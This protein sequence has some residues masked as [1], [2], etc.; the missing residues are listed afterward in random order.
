[1]IDFYKRD[2]NPINFS[3]IYTNCNFPIY[4]GEVVILQAPPAS[5]K[6]M[7]LQNLMVAFKK[8]TYFI[9]MEMSPRQI[10]SRFAMI[11][12]GWTEEQLADHY[13]Q[14][15]NGISQSFNWLT[16]DYGSL[17]T[18]E[19]EKRIATLPVK[20]EI[21]VV[22]HMGLFRSKQRDHNMKVEEAS[23]ALME[24]AVKHQVIVF[25]VSE[26][27]KQAMVEGMNIASSRGSFRVAYNAN[28]ILSLKPFK[29][30]K[31]EIKMLQLVSDKNRERETL[32]IKLGIDNVRMVPYEE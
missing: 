4:P 11:E 8:P 12:K 3:D 18:H 14:Y 22:D 17:Y 15:N 27:S 21:V 29:D 19:L 5:M 6:T 16:V 9:E 31:G 32:N 25:T 7:L 24:L 23:Q 2:L 1:M 20:P 26:I 30:D 10:W 28:K 13:K